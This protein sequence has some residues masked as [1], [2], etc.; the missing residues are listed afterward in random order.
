M[1]DLGHSWGSLERW[2]AEDRSQVSGDRLGVV[3][4]LA[5]RD[6][7]DPP[8]GRTE[9]PVPGAVALE[10]GGGVVDG[11]AV[12]LRDE[13]RRAPNA[14]AFEPPAASLEPSVHLGRRQT[15]LVHEVQEPGLELAA[16]DAAP[17]IQ[18][19]L[20]LWC[21]RSARIALEQVGQ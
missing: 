21:A 20:E 8:A 1:T 15:G 5:P 4:Q 12:Q 3:M 10:R 16:G 14:V 13:A 11:A 2:T 17:R 18:Q 6:P 19:R 9:A 7:D